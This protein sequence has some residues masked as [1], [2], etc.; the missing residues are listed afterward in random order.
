ML[1][2]QQAAGS[3]QCAAARRPFSGLPCRPSGR[4]ARGPVAAQAAM[5]L[6]DVIEK[7][8]AREDLSVQQAEESFESMLSDFVPEQVA[9]FLVLLRA[10]VRRRAGPGPRCRH[11]RAPLPLPCAVDAP[12][13]TA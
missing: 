8:I 10:K 3:R 4:P 12:E 11:G 13:A 6:R 7:L 2:R 5:Q 1:L 9:A